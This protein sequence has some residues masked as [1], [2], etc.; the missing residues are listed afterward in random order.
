MRYTVTWKPSLKAQLAKIWLA[1]DDKKAVTEATDT[2]DKLLR[3]APL[4]VGESRSGMIRIVIVRPLAV[5][6]EVFEDDRRVEVLA[7]R[8]L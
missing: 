3:V 8:H 4:S 2:I 1:A 5:A 6:Y 7:I